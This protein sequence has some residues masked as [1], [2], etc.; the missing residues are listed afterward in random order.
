MLS[1]PTYNFIGLGFDS[2]KIFW[3]ALE[4]VIHFLSFKG[5]IHVYSLKILITHDKNLNPLLNLLINCISRRSAP[6][7]LSIKSG[8]VFHFSN[9]LIIGLCNSS[10]NSL[11]V[12]F[13]IAPPD[14]FYQKNYKTLKQVP[15]HIHH[16]S[17]FQYFIRTYSSS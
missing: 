16:F 5:I 12:L 2:S 13:L 14:I 6:Q 9:V 3:K 8:C 11:L 10:A 15:F 1:L 17:D 7:I 4:T